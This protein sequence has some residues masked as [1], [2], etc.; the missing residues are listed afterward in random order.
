MFTTVWQLNSI[1]TANNEVTATT[2]ATYC[3]HVFGTELHFDFGAGIPHD[4]DSVVGLDDVIN[5]SLS[6]VVV[7]AGGDGAELTGGAGGLL[8]DLGLRRKRVL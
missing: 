2:A 5:A 4:V 1:K 7:L 3:S 8:D 6:H